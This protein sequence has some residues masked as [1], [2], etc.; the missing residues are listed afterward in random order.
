MIYNVVLAC[1]AQKSESV[2]HIDISTPS[3]A[4]WVTQMLKNLPAIQEI[5]VQSLGQEDPLEKGMATPLQYSCLRI[6]WAEEP[7]GLQSMG[8]KELVMTERLKHTH[9]HSFLDSFPSALF[10]WGG[11]VAAWDTLNLSSLARD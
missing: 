1:A 2:T 9:T 5:Q 8:S 7:G 10:L 3:R 6:P 11:G 4:S